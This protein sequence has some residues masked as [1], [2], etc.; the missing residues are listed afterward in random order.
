MTGS[1]ALGNDGGS[2][3]NLYLFGVTLTKD[4][5]I[6]S[7]DKA[8]NDPKCGHIIRVKGFAKDDA[9]GYIEVNAT[10]EKLSINHISNAQEVIIVIGENLS[11]DKIKNYFPTADFENLLK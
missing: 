3:S 7:I 10:R 5:L 2:F 8:I 11:S 9:E 1:G 6:S 4:E